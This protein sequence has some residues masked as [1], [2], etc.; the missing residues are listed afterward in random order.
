[1]KYLI[2]FLS[3]FL[4]RENKRSLMISLKTQQ[5][6]STLYDLDNYLRSKVKYGERNV[7][8]YDDV[9]KFLWDNLEGRNITYED[10][11]E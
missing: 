8:V 2:L 10:I 9:R 4:S 3:C 6:V 1:M 11:F 5:L 7:K